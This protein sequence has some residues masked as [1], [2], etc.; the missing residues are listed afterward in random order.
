MEILKIFNI[1]GH[2]VGVSLNNVF[3]INMPFLQNR[4]KRRKHVHAQE[5]NSRVVAAQ[6]IIWHSLPKDEIPISD[7]RTTSTDSST[8]AEQDDLEGM[9]PVGAATT[10]VY[11]TDGTVRWPEAKEVELDTSDAVKGEWVVVLVGSV[12]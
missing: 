11:C 7:L 10:T 4:V 2:L 6:L 9:P 3:T 1:P 8:E 12:N 5:H